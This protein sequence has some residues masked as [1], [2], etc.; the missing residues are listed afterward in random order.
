M[1]TFSVRIVQINKIAK[2]PNADTLSITDVDGC[3][4]I[5]RTGDILPGDLAVYIPVEA[6]VDFKY[7]WAQKIL[8]FFKPN[9]FGLY[10]VKAVKLRGIFSMGILLNIKEF[11]KH[12]GLGASPGQNIASILGIIKYEEPEILGTHHACAK[13][14]GNV[15]VYDMENFRK[16]RNA[17]EKHCLDGGHHIVI[18]EKIHGTNSRFGYVNNPEKTFDKSVQEWIFYF[19]SHRQFKKYDPSNMWCHIADQYQLSTK[20]I[21]YQDQFLYGET[22]GW[23]SDLK[24][25]MN[26]GQYSFAAFD[27]YDR[28]AGRFWDYPDFI[29]FCADKDIPTAPILYTGPFDINIIEELVANT[30]S[31]LASNIMEG[32]V[33]RTAKESWHPEFGRSIL[34]YLTQTYLLRKDGTEGH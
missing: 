34:K 6:V 10:R 13:D 20:L 12:A 18:T 19:G 17:F 31:T 2:H 15:P 25:D 5:F 7:N 9:S 1:S 26:V 23:V 11:Y 30:K 27:M 22:Y 8:T 14:P 32:L 28:K 16:Y 29:K 24:Y 3:P 33:I 21:S 4:V